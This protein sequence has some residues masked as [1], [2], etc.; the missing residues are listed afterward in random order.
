M[1]LDVIDIGITTMTVNTTT[2]MNV[3]LQ[4]KIKVMKWE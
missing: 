4:L 1:L 2:I 3:I